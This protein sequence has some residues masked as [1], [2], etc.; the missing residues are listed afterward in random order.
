MEHLRITME[1]FWI[2][3]VERHEEEQDRKKQPMEEPDV[4]EVWTV[5]AA[6]FG[7]SMVSPSESRQRFTSTS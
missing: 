1:N 6:F 3:Q 7:V 2:Y 4:D 5:C